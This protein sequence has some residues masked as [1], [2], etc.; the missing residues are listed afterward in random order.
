MDIH[1]ITC[2]DSQPPISCIP[3]VT[4]PTI[5]ILRVYRYK[6]ENEAKQSFRPTFINE[7]V[8]SKGEKITSNDHIPTVCN[9]DLVV[10][11]AP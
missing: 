6:G 8:E 5:I 7:V 1:I 10:K 9:H 11:G 2:H 4:E 3:I